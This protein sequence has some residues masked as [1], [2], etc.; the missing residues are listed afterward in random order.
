ML[1]AAQ[2]MTTDDD[3]SAMYAKGNRSIH[4]TAHTGGSGA[5]RRIMR[6]LDHKN[7]GSALVFVAVRIPTM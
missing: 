4:L 3:G 7:S 2:M 1:E 5:F 6:A